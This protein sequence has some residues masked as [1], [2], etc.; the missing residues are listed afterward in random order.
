MTEHNVSIGKNAGS[1]IKIP[2]VQT[3]IKKAVMLIIVIL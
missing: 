2:F 3:R 1:E